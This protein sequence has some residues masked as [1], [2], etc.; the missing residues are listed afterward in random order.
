[1]DAAIENIVTT[2]DGLF[3][4]DVFPEDSQQPRRQEVLRY[5]QAFRVRFEV[6]QSS[7]IVTTNHIL[8]I[9]ATAGTERCRVA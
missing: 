6:V 2:D 4:N 7:G 9:Q 8:A 5:R 3:R 1:V